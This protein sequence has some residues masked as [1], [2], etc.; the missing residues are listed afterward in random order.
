MA[1]AGAPITL[2]D[3][4]WTVTLDPATL[5][6]S[7]HHRDGRQAT[8]SRPSLPTSQPEALT[9][10]ATEAR[11]SLPQQKLEVTASLTEEGFRL[12]F[13]A[14]EPG[15]ITWPVLGE[16]TGL[17][18]CVLPH[19]EGFYAPIHESRWRAYL[20]DQSPFDMMEHLSMPMW[21][22]RYPGLTVAYI[23]ENP[24]DNQLQWQT[25]GP[26]LWSTLTHRFQRNQPGKRH[27]VLVRFGG[28]SPVE[29]ALLF[30][31][32]FSRHYQF[33]SYQEKIRALPDA[34][35]LL[36]AAH[37]YLWWLNT[38][39][40]DED[41][42]NWPQLA[43]ALQ[44]DPSLFPRL[45]SD[46][47]AAA[48]EAVAK[49]F[50][51]PYQK[52]AILMGLATIDESQIESALGRYLTPRERW[53]S[54]GPPQLIR[55]L[56]QAGFDRLLL[57]VDD[58]E[59]QYLRKRP[60]ALQLAR[61]YGY[62]FAPY[63]SYHSMHSPSEKETWGTAQF[64]QELY[65][66]GGIVKEDGTPSRGFK[67]KGLH[68]SSLAAKPYV[69]KRVESILRDAPFNSWF[70]DC[71]ATGELFDNYSAAFPQTKEQDMDA[72]LERMRWLRDQKHLVVGSE[73]GAWY[74]APVIHF[75]H[76]MTTPLFGWKDP[77]LRDPKSKYFLGKYYPPGAPAAFFK[78]VELP[79][80][81]R[82]LYF[83]PRYR[84]P[85]FETAFH[86]ALITTSRWEQPET[87][88]SNVT[89]TRKLLELLYGV[90]P[91]YDLNLAQFDSIVPGMKAH[92][93]F[94]SPLHREIGALPLTSFEWLSADRLLQRA[95]FGGK[96]E[97]LANFGDSEAQSIPPRSVVVK[98]PGAAASVYSPA[99]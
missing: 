71:D 78:S 52:R 74:A 1:A 55:R 98:R 44:A 85:L 35:K 29:A 31:Q 13:R 2:H 45:D 56:R 22:L 51:A 5:A 28:D 62:L 20:V 24:F 49:K 40:T 87:K 41:V 26:E 57:G 36:G 60:E 86:D 53:G 61:E 83:D 25:R 66:T 38:P 82:A 95:V 79:E 88:F 81:Y 4:A 16:E 34:E 65:D 32:W 75:G 90:P 89:E 96:V 63:D 93:K 77:L 58:S 21:G 54:H 3:G 70:V 10:T 99:K 47:Q 68:L 64:G 80:N 9:T 42:T 69:T 73:E 91:L 67:G 92:Y 50:V 17:E 48:R 46:T 19:G 37:L 97:I 59:A 27:S 94:F 8:L 7:A 6:A 30:R 76:G 12:A 39:L 18:A 23:A 43:R 72:R 84:L 11:W 15:S 33:M 14:A